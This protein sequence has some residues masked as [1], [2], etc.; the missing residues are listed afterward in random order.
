M[1]QPTTEP[2]RIRESELPLEQRCAEHYRRACAAADARGFPRPAA[3]AHR[4]AWLARHGLS[5]G[6]R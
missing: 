3:G 2:E 5:K 6:Q 4:R 1:T